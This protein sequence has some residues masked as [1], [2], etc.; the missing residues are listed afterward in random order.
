MTKHYMIGIDGDELARA[1]LA[2]KARGLAMEDCLKCLISAHLPAER[3]ESH[4]K[5]LLRE[6]RQ[7]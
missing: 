2:A 7:E 6:T 5:L 1:E 4:Q 3:P